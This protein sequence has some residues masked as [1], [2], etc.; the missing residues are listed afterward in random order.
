MSDKRMVRDS[1]FF[2]RSNPFASQRRPLAEVRLKRHHA[3]HDKLQSHEAF[4]V[5][6]AS[7][8]EHGRAH[9]RKTDNPFIVVLV[10]AI[11]PLATSGV[12]VRKVNTD[13]ELL[14]QNDTQSFHGREIVLWKKISGMKE[15]ARTHR[16]MD[17]C[18]Y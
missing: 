2:R 3:R 18:C 15:V 14:T 5:L 13:S 10:A 16:L 8:T 9:A 17:L 7:S 1:Y 11:L 6:V 4:R 12:T